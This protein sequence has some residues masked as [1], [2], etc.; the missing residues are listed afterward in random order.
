MKPAASR[1]VLATLSLAAILPAV[2]AAQSDAPK[3]PAPKFYSV[4]QGTR[5]GEVYRA[6]CG[7]C[8]NVIDHSSADFRLAWHGQ[9][10][11]ALYDYLRGTMPDDDPGKLTDQQYIDVTAYLLR[12]NGMPAGDSALVADTGVLRKLVIDIKPAG[13]PAAMLPARLHR[14]LR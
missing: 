9:T 13:G 11:R 3:A 1:V 12:A 14:L 7:K 10:V 8:H 5:G 6:Q 2:A 4:E